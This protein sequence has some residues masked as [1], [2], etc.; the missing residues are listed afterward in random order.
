MQTFSHL[1]YRDL[2]HLAEAS[3]LLAGRKLQAHQA[4][5]SNIVSEEGRDVKIAADKFAEDL[6]LSQLQANT[7]FTILTEESGWHK[8]HDHETIWIVDPL[9][10]SFNYSQNIPF[11]CVAIALVEK[12]VPKIGVI[13]DFNHE[14]LFS[15]IVGEGAWLNTEPTQ[16][17]NVSN[18]KSAMLNTGFPARADYAEAANNI[19]KEGQQFRKVRMLGSAA[20]S[21]AYVAAGRAEAYYEQGTMFWDVAAGCALVQAA[22]GNYT[23]KGDI[24]KAP[25]IALATNGKIKFGLESL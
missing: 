8:G 1:T 14:E 6:I 21:L 9:D 13:Y 3:A 23:L 24:Y 4:N 19:I 10:G 11:N 25:L 5:W 12:S 16:V 18:L 2:L 20:L 22:G 17:S 7:P 15:G